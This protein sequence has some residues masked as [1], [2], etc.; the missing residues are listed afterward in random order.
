MLTVSPDPV[1]TNPRPAHTEHFLR[2]D[3][4]KFIKKQYRDDRTGALGDLACITV[5]IPS[6]AETTDSKVRYHIEEAFNRALAELRQARAFSALSEWSL[7]N[8]VKFD[9]YALPKHFVDLGDIQGVV[10]AMGPANSR[11]ILTVL[12]VYNGDIFTHYVS[13]LNA[14]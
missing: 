14:N 11:I 3:T 4:E 5:R 8:V 6:G 12:V 13:S 10:V 2:E 9:N 7:A 1:R